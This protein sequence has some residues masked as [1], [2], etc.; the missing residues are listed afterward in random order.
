MAE[1][2]FS[3]TCGGHT[4]VSESKRLMHRQLMTTSINLKRLKLLGQ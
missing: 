1:T 3:T 2:D 4:Y